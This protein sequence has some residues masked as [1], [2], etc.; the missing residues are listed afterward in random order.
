MDPTACGMGP[1]LSHVIVTARMLVDS[2][3]LNAAASICVSGSDKE[4]GPSKN[5]QSKRNWRKGARGQFVT[6]S[7]LILL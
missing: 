6:V 2:R 4:R 3:F 7:V 1:L 5:A